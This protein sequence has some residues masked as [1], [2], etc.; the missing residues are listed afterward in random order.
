MNGPRL[1]LLDRARRAGVPVR[2]LGGG[3]RH[4]GPQQ[5]RLGARRLSRQRQPR[6]AA[7]RDRGMGQAVDAQE[8]RRRLLRRQLVD[9]RRQGG[10]HV[11]LRRP[12]AHRV[13]SA[14]LQA[15]DDRA[16]PARR[17]SD[18]EAQAALP[19]RD[20]HRRRLLALQGLRRVRAGRRADRHRADEGRRGGLHPR[21]R[22]PAEVTRRGDSTRTAHAGLPARR[23]RRAVPARADLRRALPPG[24]A[25]R[26][27][28][29][30][31]RPLRQPDVGAP[32]GGAR[33]ARGRP[34]RRLLGRDGRGQRRRHPQPAHRRR[35]RRALRRLPGHPRDRRATCS[36]PTA[37]RCG[38]C[39][40]TTA[41][42][43]PRC[44]ARRSCGSSRPPTRG[45]TCSTCRP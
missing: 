12:L 33:R 25:G 2:R 36:S 42:S 35:A 30:Q 1:L 15:L 28:A 43:A 14:A 26:R 31:L 5:A 3:P 41:P 40:P 6:H 4:Q 27:L 23:R 38:S 32:G 17:R 11:G 39:P 10:L 20:V 45:S 29:L 44:R 34:Q 19:R 9:G 16:R 13:G 21:R 24:R 18:G 22:E 7:Q 8:R 37:S